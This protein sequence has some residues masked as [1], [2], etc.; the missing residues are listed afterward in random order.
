VVGGGRSVQAAA[1]QQGQ[2]QHLV[3]IASH[4]FAASAAYYSL[5]KGTK[6]IEAVDWYWTVGVSLVL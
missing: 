1:E 5:G 4:G 2:R 6:E 3:R